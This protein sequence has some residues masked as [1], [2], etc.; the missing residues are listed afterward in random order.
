[1]SF[2]VTSISPYTDETS[3][4]LIKQAVATGKTLDHVTILPNIKGTTAMNIMDNTV[5]IAAG[6]C[7]WSAAGDVAFSQRDITVYPLKVN[8]ALCPQTLNEYWAGQQMIGTAP[9]DIPEGEIIAESYVEKI[10]SANERSFWQ[11]DL[12]GS[13][14]IGNFPGFLDILD[15]ESYVGVSAAAGPHTSSDIVAH[16]DAMVAAMP[17]V[18]Y[19]FG[20][21]VKMFMSI[22]NFRL[23]VA[24]IGALNRYHV[25]ANV[26]L[27]N[28]YY[29]PEN[30]V[31]FVGTTGLSGSDEFVLTYGKNLV[32][33]TN[34]NGEENFL[35]VWYSE[36][37]L[38]VRVAAQWS[39]GTQV[40]FPELVVRNK[41]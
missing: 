9:T 37:N 1:M 23:Y 21:D 17:E 29:N 38:E 41:A 32:V 2:N 18:L 13:P 40:Q 4:K 20:K 30:G 6:A 35:K 5:T 33:G 7:S 26:G 3:Q 16:V 15:G 31:T 34:I 25:P 11:G 8:D 10:K 39:Y 27:E 19:E 28:E 24:A 14:V 22:A 12:V 36:D